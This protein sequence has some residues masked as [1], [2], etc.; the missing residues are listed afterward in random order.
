MTWRKSRRSNPSGNCVEVDLGPAPLALWVS[1]ERRKVRVRD[2][3]DPGP[4]LA[5]TPAAWA[6]FVAETR[7][8]ENQD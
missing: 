7:R 3:K 5:F 8:E 2:S 6:A 1:G 4:V